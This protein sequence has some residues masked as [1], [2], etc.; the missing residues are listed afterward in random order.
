MLDRVRWGVSVDRHETM[1]RAKSGR[2]LDV[3]LT[4]CPLTD[5]R[6]RVVSALSIGRDVTALKRAESAHQASEARWC[7]IVESAVDGIMLISAQ[8]TIEAFNPAA[9]QLF[10][11][12]ATEILGRNVNVLMPPPYRFEHDQYLA[13]YIAGGPAKMIRIGRE[14]TARRRNGEDFPARLSVGEMSVDGETRFTG[15]VHDLTERV[16]MEQRLREQA[17]LATL[18]EM[19]AVV[20]HEVRNALAAV[21]EAVQVIGARVPPDSR[22]ALVVPDVVG[23]IDALSGIVKDMLLFAH[24]PQP[25]LNPVDLAQLI[26]STADATDNDPNLQ[27]VRMEVIAA[28]PSTLGDAELLRIVFSNLFTNSAQA[29]RGTG[30]IQVLL[31]PVGASCQI[32]V[33]DRGPGNPPE[34]RERLF[35]PFFT[36]KARGSG[37]GLATAKRIVEGHE[38]SLRV[39]C[40]AGGGT[41]VIVQL[42]L[43]GSME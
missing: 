11:Y 21:R 43:R 29:M 14:V 19:A 31:E 25:R 22:E 5:D 3:W 42:P 30:T 8:G 28:V 12:A 23:R 4:V 33:A 13:N 18:G 27:N 1:R 10:G 40:P 6:G 2:P 9:E 24:L 41:M 34:V 7:A 26:G 39:E 15:I 35:T 38:G 32:V 17:A 37:L 20:A 36:T 16:Q